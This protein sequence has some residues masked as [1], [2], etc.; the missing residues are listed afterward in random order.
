MREKRGRAYVPVCWR[1]GWER[2]CMPLLEETRC[3]W[4]ASGLF[5][6]SFCPT[7]THSNA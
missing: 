6:E 3:S 5:L 2:G 7:P 1:I 4:K